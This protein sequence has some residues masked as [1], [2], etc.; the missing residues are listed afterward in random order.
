MLGGGSEIVV[1]GVLV[2]GGL[3]DEDTEETVAVSELGARVELTTGAEDEEE[4][5]AGTGVGAE[6][7]W[8]EAGVEV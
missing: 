6:D 8:T 5:A 4:A 2:T 3:A 7:T 1:A